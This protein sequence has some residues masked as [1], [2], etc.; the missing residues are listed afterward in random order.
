LKELEPGEKAFS[1]LHPGDYG[2]KTKREPSFG[3]YTTIMKP[4]YTK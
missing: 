2:L 4:Y 3:N 1:P